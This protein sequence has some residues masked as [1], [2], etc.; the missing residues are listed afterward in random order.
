MFFFVCFYRILLKELVK[1]GPVGLVEREIDLSGT[2]GTV[3]EWVGR[4]LQERSMPQE[5]EERELGFWNEGDMG[6]ALSA[7]VR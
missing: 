7:D 6:W 3:Y 4:R 1:N 2:A 5:W